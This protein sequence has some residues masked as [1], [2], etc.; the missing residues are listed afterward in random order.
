MKYTSQNCITAFLKTKS[1]IF[2]EVSSAKLIQGMASTAIN[3]AHCSKQV[4]LCCFLGA[5]WDYAVTKAT[6]TLPSWF[7]VLRYPT[8]PYACSEASQKIRICLEL[9]G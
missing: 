9:V 2:V 8:E 7:S 5:T 1:I 6:S 4:M 3:A